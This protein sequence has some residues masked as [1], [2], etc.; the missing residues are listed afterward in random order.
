MYNMVIR[1]YNLQITES[2]TFKGDKLG[3]SKEYCK[4]SHKLAKFIGT[5]VIL[6][7]FSITKRG[8]K[9]RK[10]EKRYLIL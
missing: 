6:S 4:S 8:K 2:M 1:P 10:Q 7:A 3:H 5:S 9:E